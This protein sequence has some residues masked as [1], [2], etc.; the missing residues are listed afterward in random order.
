MPS[1]AEMA[2][3]LLTFLLIGAPLVS[4]TQQQAPKRALHVEAP[5]KKLTVRSSPLQDRQ[6]CPF[7]GDFCYESYASCESCFGTGFIQCPGDTTY[8]YK[9]GDV[10]HPIESCSDSFNSDSDAST[11]Y[12]SKYSSSAPLSSSYATSTVSY[13][14]TSSATYSAAPGSTSTDYCTGNCVTCWGA[15]YKE[16]PRD[17]GSSGDEYYDSSATV[18]SSIGASSDYGFGSTSTLYGTDYSISSVSFAVS[19]QAMSTSSSVAVATSY[20]TASMSDL[21]GA[22]AASTS[23]P[24]A[25][26]GGAAS[27]PLASSLPVSALLPALGFVLGGAYLMAI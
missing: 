26:L 25:Y 2:S 11:S 23:S 14:Y 22:T 17:D 12:S 18:T 24:A 3:H 1:T 7:F 9:P 13:Q 8:C 6:D 16:C 5:A 15:G 10:C 27:H 20:T 21:T 19:S 4:A